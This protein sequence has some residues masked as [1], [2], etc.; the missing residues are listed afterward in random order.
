M[1]DKKYIVPDCDYFIDASLS[2]LVNSVTSTTGLTYSL[3]MN[4]IQRV[5]TSSADQLH[6]MEY[7]ERLSVGSPVFD[8]S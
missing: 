2:H 5:N 7:Y 1:T 4:I 3:L 8:H 6:T